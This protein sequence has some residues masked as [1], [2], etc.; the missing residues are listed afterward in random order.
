MSK[1]Y[2]DLYQRFHGFKPVKRGYKKQGES[3]WYYVDPRYKNDD[4]RGKIDVASENSIN[5]RLKGILSDDMQQNPEDYYIWRTKGDDKVR[6]KHAEREG[7]IFNKH[8]PPEGGNPGEDYNCRCWAEPYR[9]E[10]TA[11]KPIIIDLSGLDMFK[12]QKTTDTKNYKQYAQNDK[13]G[14][15]NDATQSKKIDY[16]RYGEGFSKEFIDNMLADK[17]Y[18]R[19]LNE[20]VIPNEKGYVNNPKDPGGETNMGI[21]KRYH[22]NEDIK[23]LTRERANAIL[24][25]EVW[26]WNGINKL[27]KEIRGF[28]FDHGVRT[29]PQ[30]AI[31]TTHQALEIPPGGTI[32]GNTTLNR[33][34]DINYENF[35][36][37]YQNLVKK[38][39]K[40]NLNYR[41]FGKGW[42]KRT[43]GYHVSY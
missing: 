40:N 20:Y 37:K 33:L 26:N 29:S 21:A 18:Q 32:I 6:G 41:Y 38:Q 35:L 15:V 23:N 10:K 12:D 28:V 13:S 31:N 36:R 43:N 14:V 30:N 4:E 34:H 24:Y 19:A 11:D 39:D 7:K 27:P 1:I 5:P 22:S 42:D 8:I 25:K 9:P 2:N 17:D 3:E 16:S